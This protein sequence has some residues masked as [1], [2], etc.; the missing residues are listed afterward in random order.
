MPDLGFD[1][2]DGAAGLNIQ[3]DRLPNERLYED[4]RATAR[5]E[6]KMNCALFLD[7]VVEENDYPAIGV[8]QRS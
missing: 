1:L 7:V 3:C 8:Q 6:D 2:V 4:L 5:A